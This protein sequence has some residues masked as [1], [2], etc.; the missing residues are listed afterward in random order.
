MFTGSVSFEARIEGNGLTFPALVFNPKEPGVDRV[1]M[2]GPSG[3]EIRSTVHISSAASPDD[4][5]TLAAKVNKA[6]LDRITF[7]HAIAIKDARITGDNFSPINPQPGVLYASTGLYTYSGGGAS[8]TVGVNAT[9]LKSELEH[10][11]PP[12]ERYYALFR[13][14]RQSA[15]P[16]EEYMHIYHIILML[17]GDRQ[18]DVDRFIVSEDPAVP[19]TQHPQKRAGVMETVYTRL[20]N[21]FAHKRVGVDLQKTK[22][23]MADQLAGLRNLAKLA[24]ELSG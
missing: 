7:N 19:Q 21:E 2:E 20:R 13:S 16:A 14:A 6:A 9:T 23:D 1:E 22:A 24:I 15:S 8:F 3:N 12:G 5:R 4:G 10:P 17:F 18:Q 11:S